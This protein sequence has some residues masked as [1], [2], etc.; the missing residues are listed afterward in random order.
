M[1]VCSN[2][3]KPIVEHNCGHLIPCCPGKC[4]GFAATLIPDGIMV[5]ESA[6]VPPGAIGVDTDGFTWYANVA[7][8]G[9]GK[10]REK[11]WP[12]VVVAFV[13]VVAMIGSLYA[14]VFVKF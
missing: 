12:I 3:G 2:C 4:P 1:N 11:N 8:P 5:D 10:K 6:D 13:A 9:S 7:P 14:L